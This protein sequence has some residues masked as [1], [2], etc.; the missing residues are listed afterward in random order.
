MTIS[1]IVATYGDLSW[2]RKAEKAAAS[3]RSQLTV[4]DELIQ[5]HGGD[6][7]QH[8]RNNAAAEATGTWLAFLDADDSLEPG[9]FDAMRKAMPRTVHALLAPAIR[10]VDQ[11]GNQSEAVIPNAALNRPLY[12]LNRCCIGTL[13]PRLLFEKIGG[14]GP[15]SIWEDW[16]TFCRCHYDEGA[17][18]IEVPKA[19]YRARVSPN[20]RNLAV[21]PEGMAMYQSV[22]AHYAETYG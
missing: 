19:V 13:V 21:S 2:A 7:L 16:R 3:A 17:S 18:I 5:V 1:V 12:E 22:R 6:T 11:W 20:G 14:F 9:Y 10:Y 4:A 15:E 8:A